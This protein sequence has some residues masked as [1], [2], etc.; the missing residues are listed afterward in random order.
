MAVDPDPGTA[1]RADTVA[2]GD[3]EEDEGGREE[4]DTGRR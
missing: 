1:S 3:E 2:A 4:L